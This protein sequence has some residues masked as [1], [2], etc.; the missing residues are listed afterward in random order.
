[1]SRTKSNDI[2]LSRQWAT[3][4]DDERFLSLQNLEQHLQARTQRCVEEPIDCKDIQVRALPENQLGI[5]TKNGLSTFTNWSFGQLCTSA[6]APGAYLM[7]IPSELAGI[8]LQ[9]GLQHQAIR[10]KTKLYIDRNGSNILRCATGPDYGRFL[11]LEIVQQII[12]MNADGRFQIPS[13][14]YAT[15]NPKRATTLYAGDRDMFLFLVDPNHSITVDNETIFR[16]FYVQH[17]EVGKSV[18][19]FCSFT[20]NY[21]CDNR[22][23][24]GMGDVKSL[25]IKHSK[26]APIRFGNEAEKALREFADSSMIGLDRQVKAAK[27]LNVAK[28]DEG[29]TDWLKDRG[30]SGVVSGKILDAIKTE[31]YDAGSLWGMVQGVTAYARAIPFA[32]VRTEVEKTAGKLLDKY[33]PVPVELAA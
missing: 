6:G 30:F 26:N 14:S 19:D 10:E 9:Y 33:A 29:V 31:G 15:N 25:R 13:A 3:R 32:D 21:I 11:D 5:E 8:N 27:A 17:S 20:Y 28:D 16:G 12:R 4:P 1:M 7:K 22:I 23:V 18:F 2:T 24:W